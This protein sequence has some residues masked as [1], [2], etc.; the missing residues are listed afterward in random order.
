[1]LFGLVLMMLSGAAVAEPVPVRVVT[2]AA[3]MNHPWSLAFLPGGDLLVTERN[4]GLRIIHDGK[5]EPKPISGV[6][7]AF[8]E[9]DGGLLGLTLHPEFARNGLIYICL[10]IGTNAANA[11]SVIR[12]RLVGRA[13]EEVTTIFTAVPLKKEANHFGCRLM[14]APDGKLLVTLGD[15]RWYPYQAQALDND[16]GK[17]ARLND[18]GTIPA[19]NPFARRWLARPEIYTYGHRNIQ[20]IALNPLTGEVWI[21][22][23]GP[24]GGDEV[25]ILHAGANYGWP[26]ITYGIDYSGQIVS[27]K[28]AMPGMEQPVIYWTP[29]IAPSGMAFYTGARIPQW[30]GDLFVGALA[31]RHL[32]RVHFVGTLIVSQEVLLAELGERIREVCDAPDGYLYVTTDATDGRILRLEPP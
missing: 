28:T 15:G 5:L 31:G 6:P 9:H 22:E 20:G 26:M 24:K 16:L 21:H 13:L 19:D 23:H 2:V 12:G 27:E 3:G 18:D 14:F 4:G 1:M 8:A 17:V 7:I 29:S 25:N 32:R 10:S 30:R 11:S